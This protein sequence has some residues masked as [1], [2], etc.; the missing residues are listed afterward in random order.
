MTKVDLLSDTV[1][2]DKAR[3][4]LDALLD[5]IRKLPVKTAQ[6]YG[7]RQIARQQPL[8]VKEFARHQRERAEQKHESASERA[9][10][11]L[12]SEIQFWRLVEELCDSATEWSVRQEGARH[13]P[14]ELREENIP[15]RRPGMTDDERRNRN[16][17]RQRQR[18]WSDSWTM[19]HVPAFFERFCTHALYRLKMSETNHGDRDK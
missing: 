12:K 19:T 18:K 1:Y 10:S 5:E 11:I 7:L 9:K 2:R 6:I 13:A 8:R 4:R 15:P 14:P 16:Q 17:L 3:K